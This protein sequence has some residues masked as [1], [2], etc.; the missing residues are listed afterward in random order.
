MDTFIDNGYN[1]CILRDGIPES[2]L[3]SCNYH[4]EPIHH[5]PNGMSVFKSKFLPVNPGEIACIG[6]PVECIHKMASFAGATFKVRYLTNFLSR[7]SAGYALQIDF[8]PISDA[9]METKV[10]MFADKGIP[11][12]D[13]EKHIEND[14]IHTN[15]A[16]LILDFYYQLK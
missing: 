10:N 2:E 16:I 13:E 12:L 1:C 15:D 3:R 7:V 6:G 8:F 5:L 14:D 4:P 9:E 11:Q